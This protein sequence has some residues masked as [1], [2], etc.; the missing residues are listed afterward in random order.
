MMQIYLFSAI[1]QNNLYHSEIFCHSVHCLKPIPPRYFLTERQN[2][3]GANVLKMSEL[4]YVILKSYVI[5][6]HLFDRL[7]CLISNVK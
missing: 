5:L 2:G 4:T 6:F 3:Q 1:R 7:F